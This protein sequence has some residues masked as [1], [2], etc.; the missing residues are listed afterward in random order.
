MQVFAAEGEGWHHQDVQHQPPVGA[1][2]RPYWNKA[3]PAGQMRSKQAWAMRAW[4]ELLITPRDLI[5]FNLAIDSKVRGCNLV[6]LS[7]NCVAG[8]NHFASGV[9]DRIGPVRLRDALPQPQQGGGNI[10][11]KSAGLML[12]SHNTLHSLA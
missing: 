11:E 3:Q 6:L 12:H 8:G 5:S 10:L 4:L 9:S 7:G 1:A 2:R